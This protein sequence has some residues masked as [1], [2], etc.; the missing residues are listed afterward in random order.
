MGLV[1]MLVWPLLIAGAFCDINQ[2]DYVRS[3]FR[4]FEPHYCSDLESAVGVQAY[5]SSQLMKVSAEIHP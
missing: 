4:A 3:L 2:R 1:V 5:F